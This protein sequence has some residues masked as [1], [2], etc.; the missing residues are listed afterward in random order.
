[1]FLLI[2]LPSTNT[3]APDPNLILS[4]LKDFCKSFGSQISC[5]FLDEA[6]AGSRPS[7]EP[8][9]YLVCLGQIALSL[10]THSRTCSMPEPSLYRL[11]QWAPLAPDW[12]WA[13]RTQAG[14]GRE[15]GYMYSPSCLSVRSLHTAKS[16]G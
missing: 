5:F 1:M 9:W 4:H 14:E 12:V 13:R 10:H 16:L 2:K 8:P 11:F 6:T 3:L 15:G 7:S